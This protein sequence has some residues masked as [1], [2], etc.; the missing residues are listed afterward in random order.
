MENN[1]PKPYGHAAK[2]NRMNKIYNPPMLDVPVLQ[3]AENQDYSVIDTGKRLPD[4]QAAGYT[5]N[6]LGKGMR[7]VNDG[8]AGIALG[9]GELGFAAIKNRRI[10]G[11]AMYR[12]TSGGKYDPAGSLSLKVKPSH[13]GMGIGS[14]LLSLAYMEFPICLADQYYTDEGRVFAK[15]WAVKNSVPL[16]NSEFVDFWLDSMQRPAAQIEKLTA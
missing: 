15:N 13:Q 1:R 2:G 9:G 8:Y 14:D 4:F 3:K 11:Y 10:V 16:L 7:F 12:V 6:Q 5:W